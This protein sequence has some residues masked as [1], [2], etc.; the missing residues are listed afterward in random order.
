MGDYMPKS[1]FM[2]PTFAR[3]AR[4]VQ[5]GP[6]DADSMWNNEYGTFMKK[7]PDGPG[8]LLYAGPQTGW[9]PEDA[10]PGMDQVPV[11]GQAQSSGLDA[12]MQPVKRGFQGLGKALG[13]GR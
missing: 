9:T 4:E 12:L 13:I 1:R 8:I 11:Q 2:Q 5:G 7:N 10:F 3:R 6:P